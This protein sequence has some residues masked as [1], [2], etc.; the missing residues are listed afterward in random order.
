MLANGTSGKAKQ[1][2]RLPTSNIA[3]RTFNPIRNVVEGMKIVPNKD[4]AMIPL[5]IGDP[6]VFGNLKAP[7]N[8]VDALAES[9]HSFKWNGYNSSLGH[10]SARQA[11]AKKYSTPEAPLTEKD[12]V[13]ANGS[14]GALEMCLTAVAST[15][16]N[17]LVP[18]PGFPI[19]E[20]ILKSRGMNAKHYHLLPDR[21]WE[22]DLA[23][24]ESQIDDQTAAILL[25]NPSNPCGSNYSQRHL[26]DL[27]EVAERHYL[28]IISDEI[29]ADMVF[30]DDKFT[31]LGPLSKTVPV[32]TC[33]GISKQYLVPGW[34]MG[35]I[36]MYDR[37]GALD[38][39]RVGIENMTQVLCG[40]NALVQGAM[41][42]ILHS[43]PYEFYVGLNKTLQEHAE[44][45]FDRLSKIDGLHPLMSQGTM[46]L[47][48]QIEMSKFPAFKNDVDFCE[49]L[50]AEQSVFCLPAVCFGY[51]NY[52]RIV[53]TS[54]KDKLEEAY[55]RMSEFCTKY[56]QKEE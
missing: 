6:T 34:R 45:S 51:P 36:L 46:Y 9:L 40:P 14:T 39:I 13:L 56:R 43:T 25:N 7:S 50:V 49:A 44:L 8:A 24:L 31:A 5:V 2:W 17:V 42:E 19:Y 4:K 54:P 21:Q 20:T 41:H 48:V 1:G 38:E 32:L 47:M 12:V 23:D 15:G 10:V 53:F 37:I 29:Y 3:K 30:G 55:D 11:V 35:W 26:E 18:L 22:I 16:Q 33:S 52:M 28:P 27:L